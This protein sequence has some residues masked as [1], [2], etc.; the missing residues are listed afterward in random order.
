MSLKD[1]LTPQK[2][3]SSKVGLDIRG[4]A[5]LRDAIAAL[6]STGGTILVPEGRYFAGNWDYSANYM[7]TAN[8]RIVGV[9]M[10]RLSP[11]ADRL[12]DGSVIYGRFNAFADAFQAEN[13]GFDMGKYTTDTLYPGYDTHTA[14][15]PL[16]G[17]WDAFAFAQP[18]Q[19][20]PLA[21]RAGFRL[22]NVIG[23][24]RD[25]LSV[26]HSV[27]MEAIDGGTVDN[28]TGVY[29]T[30]AVAIKSRNMRIGKVSGW[31]ASSNN[32]IIKSDTYASCGHIS[33]E[34]V[35]GLT[36]FPGISSPWSAPAVATNGVNLNPATA[37]FAGPIQIGRLKVMG[38]GTA[39]EITGG[40]S[41]VIADVEI[42]EI[43]ADGTTGTMTSGI[44]FD[45]CR[46]MRFQVGS[47]IVNNASQGIA[48][49]PATSGDNTS[50]QISIGTAQLT[51][52]TTRGINASLYGRIRIGS[53]EISSSPQA[54]YCDD[55]ARIMIGK[56]TLISVTN[57]WERT[58]PA[59]ATGWSNYGGGNSTFDVMLKNYGVE[60]KGLLSAG[61]GV[62]GTIASLPVYLRPAESK[63]LPGYL[64]TGTR[65]YALIGIDSGTAGVTINDGTAPA[66]GNYASVDGVGW[67]HW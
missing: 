41:N 50:H 23:L 26:G 57:K 14:N 30:H 12:Q 38:S 8:V 60:I 55:T 9:K 61:S 33:A 7:A 29:G 13:V 1:D 58:P 59:L 32:V 19:G 67:Q 53:L 48:W 39:L 62:T 37:S 16:G 43:M 31:G 28:V 54:Y 22:V 47:L 64:N 36:A 11:T 24:T 2:S 27:L 45:T 66:S 35:E 63:R 6:P 56:E 40:A 65:N 18:N 44:N 10:P 20:T 42:A 17:T 34:Y 52:M 4:Y 51:T 15:H 46:A 25:S 21:A 5:S 3:L 49:A